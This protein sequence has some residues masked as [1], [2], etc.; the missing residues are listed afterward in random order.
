MTQMAYLNKNLALEKPQAIARLNNILDSQAIPQ[1][2]HPSV[3]EAG[4]VACQ[5][6][7]S[8]SRIPIPIDAGARVTRL[9]LYC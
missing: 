9:K 1:T 8:W 6:I 5:M 3:K 7:K 4:V 2:P